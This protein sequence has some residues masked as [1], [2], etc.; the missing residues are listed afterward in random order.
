VSPVR[1]ELGFYVTDDGI[2]HGHRRETS[3][4]TF[5]QTRHFIVRSRDSKSIPRP[6]RKAICEPTVWTMWDLNIAQP[7]IAS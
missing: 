2:L 4:L 6:A 3:T 1:Y 7:S 5:I